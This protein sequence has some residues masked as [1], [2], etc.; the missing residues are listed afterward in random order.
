MLSAACPL[1][2]CR[3]LCQCQALCLCPL[4]GGPPSAAQQRHQG[5]LERTLLTQEVLIHLVWDVTQALAFLKCAAKIEDLLQNLDIN[6]E[7]ERLLTPRLGGR[8]GTQERGG[9]PLMQQHSTSASW[10]CW[11]GRVLAQAPIFLPFEGE[12]V[13]SGQGKY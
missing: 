13:S 12:I 6:L 2:L 11:R 9:K 1:P 8:K 7:L 10:C 3:P 4:L 5:G